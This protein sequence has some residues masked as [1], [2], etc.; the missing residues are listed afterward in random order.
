MT[1]LNLDNLCSASSRVAGNWEETAPH[2][3]GSGARHQAQLHHLH[4]L[5]PRSLDLPAWKAVFFHSKTD[6][7]VI[8]GLIDGIEEL[9]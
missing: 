2:L 1:I 8:D 6:D 9:L 4:W 3:A 7:S 5:P